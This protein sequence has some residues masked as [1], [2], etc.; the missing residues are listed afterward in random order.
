MPLA[1][2]FHAPWDAQSAESLRRH[3][4]ELDWLIPGWV[5]IT[6]ADHTITDVPRPGRPRGDQRRGAP[7]ADPAD[8]PERDRAGNGTAPGMAALLARSQARAALLDRLEP[9]LAANHAGGAFFDFEELPPSRAGRL[10]R[11][12]ERGA[13]RGSTGTAG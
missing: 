10:P 12:P 13:T 11:V 6:G 1:I 2:A 8:D 9:W 3:I 7:A 5:S 4:D